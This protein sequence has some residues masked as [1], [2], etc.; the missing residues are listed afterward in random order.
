MLQ[1]ATNFIHTYVIP[2][3]SPAKCRKCIWCALIG[4]EVQILCYLIIALS[5]C[6]FQKLWKEHFEIVCELICP[7]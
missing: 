1:L 7:Q 4:R 6:T 2:F 3:Q 5:Y